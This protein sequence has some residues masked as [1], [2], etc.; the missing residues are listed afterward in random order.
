M[1]VAEIQGSVS[2]RQVEHADKMSLLVYDNMYSV[3]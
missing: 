2:F 3:I 1:C